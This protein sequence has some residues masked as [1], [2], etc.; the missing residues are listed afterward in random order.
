[1]S[2]YFLNAVAISIAAVSTSFAGD[3]SESTCSS[4]ES[5]QQE[6]VVQESPAQEIGSSCDS[7][8]ETESAASSDEA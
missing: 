2:K 8:T 7:C 1:M 4:C 6:C 5:T 3:D